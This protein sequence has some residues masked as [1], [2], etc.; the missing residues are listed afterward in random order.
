VTAGLS[1]IVS[2][3]ALVGM[4]LV[5]RNAWAGWALLVVSEALFIVVSADVGAWGFIP[6]SVVFLGVYG[7]NLARWRT[8]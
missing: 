1:V 8:A 5:G 6:V 4:W 3:L 2:V 7:R